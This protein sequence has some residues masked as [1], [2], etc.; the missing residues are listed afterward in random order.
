[1]I[2][3]HSGFFAF[4]M[5]ITVG[6]TGGGCDTELPSRWAQGPMVIDGQPEEWRNVDLFHFEGHQF[7]F[8]VQNDAH[9]LYL[10]FSTSD[11]LTQRWLSELGLTVWLNEENAKEQSFGIRLRPGRGEL[12]QLHHPEEGDALE[13]APRTPRLRHPRFEIV[14]SARVKE[15]SVEVGEMSFQGA[16]ALELQV[17]FAAPPAAE[18]REVALGLE[19]TT[20]PQR[21]RDALNG[22][23]RG[24]RHGRGGMGG[25]MPGGGMGGGMPGG[26]MGGGMPGGGTGGGMPGGGKAKGGGAR[27]PPPQH[28]RSLH[29]VIWISVQLAPDPSRR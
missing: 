2:A 16:L 23:G 17:A 15:A 9:H 18:R 21:Q 8:S 11:R 13:E 24:R 5:L 19:V 27:R 12:A 3:R 22:S 7:A 20:N 26:G 25:G 14:G 10:Y 28:S 6:V 29:E 1:M 4:A